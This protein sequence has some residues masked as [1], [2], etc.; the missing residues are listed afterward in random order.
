MTNPNDKAVPTVSVTQ[1]RYNQFPAECL[2]LSPEHFG[3]L[4]AAVID[5]VF[6]NIDL[7]SDPL[8]LESQPVL[9]SFLFT[10][11]STVG[12]GRL[13]VIEPQT[14]VLN[15]LASRYDACQTQAS[16]LRKQM[17]P[18][19]NLLKSCQI[20]SFTRVNKDLAPYVVSRKEIFIKAGCIHQ[21]L[22]RYGHPYAQR[23]KVGTE[24]GKNDL[25]LTNPLLFKSRFHRSFLV[26]NISLTCERQ[27]ISTFTKPE[28]SNCR[29][30]GHGDTCRGDHYGHSVPPDHAIVDTQLFAAEDA[31]PFAHSLNPLWTSGHSATRRD[32][33]PRAHHPG[34]RQ[35]A[36]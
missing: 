36:A 32:T 34:H 6:A 4:K 26:R 2:E 14:G 3:C 5:H 16:R 20:E 29:K 11:L 18:R 22:L 13:F 30:D 24:I 7:P 1:R 27:S 35:A 19:K 8:V 31:I 9:L 10:G 21:L 23:R 12:Q 33:I 25:F 28:N 17:Q 15:D